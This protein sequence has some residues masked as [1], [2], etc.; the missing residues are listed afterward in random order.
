MYIA[1]VERWLFDLLIK[2]RQLYLPI[3]Y[4]LGS[5]GSNNI[6]GKQVII[7]GVGKNIFLGSNVILGDNVKI[8]CTNEHSTITIGDN[9]IIHFG[10]YIDTGPG[11]SI[12]LGTNNS[13]NPHCVIYGHGGLTTGR[14]VR[15]AAHTVIIPANHI[16]RNPNKPITKQGLT[17]EGIKIND[18]VWI[19]SGC[20]ILDGVNI[21]HGSVVG[22]GA[23]VTKSVPPMAV[24]AGVPASIIKMRSE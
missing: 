19:G 20:R 4:E 23:V 7:E 3:K 24:V 22:A 2:F 11:G 1:R 17:K 10:A 5:C 21:G 15:I 6:F 14:Y 12:H 16:F 18:D 8:I 13:I 9:T